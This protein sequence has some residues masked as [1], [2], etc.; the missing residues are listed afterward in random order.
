MSLAELCV[1][2]CVHSSCFLLSAILAV[3]SQYISHLRPSLTDLALE[4]WP[5]FL[6]FSTGFL[7]RWFEEDDGWAD[8]LKLHWQY[9]CIR[10]S[11]AE[12]A[13]KSV[14]DVLAESWAHTHTRMMSI[15][16]HVCSSSQ[17]THTAV[18]NLKRHNIKTF[19]SRDRR[20]ISRS[21]APL[22]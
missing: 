14:T 9:I 18:K 17:H 10:L 22:D 11:E 13:V 12:A 21:L 20:L 19:F 2:V 15:Q 1:C 5:T 7:R 8:R 6:W 3:W 16:L 4:D